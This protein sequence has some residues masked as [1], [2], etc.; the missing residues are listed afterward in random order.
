MD[1]DALR[2][3][4]EKLCILWGDLEEQKSALARAKAPKAQIPSSF[5]PNSSPPPSHNPGDQ[6]PI[7]SDD[8][9]EN[10]RPRGKPQTRSVNASVLSERDS[11]VK[12]KGQ[13]SANGDQKSSAEPQIKNKGFTCCIKQYGVEVNEMDPSLANAGNGKRWD[14]KFGLFGTKIV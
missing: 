10:S 6:P 8:E 1:V 2:E 13:A 11:N 7:D 14:R 12:T 3:V 5:E 4:K 9:D